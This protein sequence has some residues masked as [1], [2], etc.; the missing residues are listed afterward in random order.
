MTWP[1]DNVGYAGAMSPSGPTGP[2]GADGADGAAATIA[3]GDVASV[4]YGTPPTVTNVGTPAAAIFDFELETGA[5]GDQGEAGVSASLFD[6][7]IDGNLQPT[8]GGSTD[9]YY[10]LD[11]ND[12]L[13]PI[14]A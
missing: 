2:A 9:E 12:D 5:K 8:T 1:K 11:G 7:D 14:A 3:V 4:P 6:I 10:E 13:M